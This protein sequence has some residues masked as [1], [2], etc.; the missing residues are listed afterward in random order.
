MEKWNY[1]QQ[2]GG[3]FF[4]CMLSNAL[5]LA[6]KE[7]LVKSDLLYTNDWFVVA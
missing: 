6:R 2:Y 4:H 1:N 7:G 5:D 3:T